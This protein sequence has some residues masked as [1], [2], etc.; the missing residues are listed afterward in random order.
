MRMDALNKYR[1]SMQDGL[2]SKSDPRSIVKMGTDY[3]LKL[4]IDP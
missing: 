3:N 2:Y 1:K 4:N